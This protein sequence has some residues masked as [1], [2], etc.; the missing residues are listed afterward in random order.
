MINVFDHIADNGWGKAILVGF[1][2]AAKTVFFLAVQHIFGPLQPL[3]GHGLVGKATHIP[4]VAAGVGHG[5]KPH[6]ALLGNRSLA[7]KVMAG[8]FKGQGVIVNLFVEAFL[9]LILA[10]ILKGH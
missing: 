7:D 9:G 2:N 5:I 10:K 3:A 8:A 1:H 6:S 4:G